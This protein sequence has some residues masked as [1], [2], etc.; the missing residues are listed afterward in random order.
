M[1]ESSC[2]VLIPVNFDWQTVNRRQD[3]PAMYRM[4]GSVW[5]Y[6]RDTFVARRKAYGGKIVMCETASNPIDVDTMVE[7]L[8]VQDLIQRANC[9]T[10]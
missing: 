2:G 7:F 6:R 4:A 9:V 5:A 1:Y 8:H 3:R 10:M